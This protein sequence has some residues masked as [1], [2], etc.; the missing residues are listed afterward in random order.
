MPHVGEAG[1][2]RH[3][4]SDGI[5]ETRVRHYRHELRHLYPRLASGGVLIVDDYG[6]WDGARRAV[7]EHFASEAEPV[8]LHRTDYTGRVAVKP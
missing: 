4:E 3:R 2:G 7:D 6:H 8:L 5:V 1:A